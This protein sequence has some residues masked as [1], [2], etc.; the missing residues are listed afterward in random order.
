MTRKAKVTESELFAIA[1]YLSNPDCMVDI[2]AEMPHDFASDFE[3][4]YNRLTNGSELPEPSSRGPYFIW[5]P[6]TNK[7]GLELRFYFIKIGEVPTELEE[8]Y[9]NL[10]PRT[11]ARRKNYIRVNHT[12]L[13]YQ[14][15]ECGFQIGDE[16]NRFRIDQ[17]M[18]R[19]FSR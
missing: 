5:E 6:G 18:E 13:V 1:N 4:E 19:R 16:Q 8:L 17:F 10:S 2:H 12:N 11:W 15:F 3:H 14:L 7:F 9:I